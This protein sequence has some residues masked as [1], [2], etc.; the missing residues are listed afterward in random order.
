[1]YKISNLKFSYK[2]EL[3]LKN[4]N[5]EFKDTGLYYIVGESGSGKST[6]LNLISSLLSGYSGNI[7][8]KNKELSSFS[9]EEKLNY[10]TN[11]V[12]ICLQEDIFDYKLS[13]MDNL[14]LS[15][16]IF[17]ISKEE[18]IKK[19]KYYAKLIKVSSLLNKRINDLSGGELKRM[20]LLRCLIREN[21]ILL[22]DEPLGPLDSENS[23]NITMFLQKLAKTCLIIVITHNIDDI[24]DYTSIIHFKDGQISKIENG[25]ILPS[26]SFTKIVSHRKRISF[27]ENL[28][29]AIKCLYAKGKY[30]TFMMFS[31]TIALTSIGLVLLLTS[32]IKLSLNNM[33]ISSFSNNTMLIKQNGKNIDSSYYKGAS[34]SLISNLQY[35][36][37]NY[38][39]EVIS[40]YQINYETLFTNYN[41]TYFVKDNLKLNLNSITCRDFGEFFYY[42]ETPFKQ[43]IDFELNYDELILV[44][45]QSEINSIANFYNLDK[46]DTLTNLNLLASNNKLILNL[47]L[48]IGSFGYDY[49]TSFTIKKVF[50]NDFSYI[51]HTSS[52]FSNIFIEEELQFL[53]YTDFNEKKDVPWS[54][55]K[56]SYLLIEE[57]SIE[58]FIYEVEKIASF[59]KLLLKK[60]SE[61]EFYSLPINNRRLLVYID[62]QEDISI[63]KINKILEKYESEIANIS[64]SDSLYYTSD[65]GNLSGFL[66]P[67]YVSSKLEKINKL[68]D[69]NYQTKFNLD[70]FQ[71]T[72][73]VFDED[74]IMGDLSNTQ[75]NP[76]KFSSL[77]DP[78]ISY[79]ENYS[80]FNEV[81]ISSSLAK[82]LFG[83][84]TNSLNNTLHLCLLKDITFENDI[85]KNN[86]VKGILK[87]KGVVEEESN[88]IYQNE[89]F[90]KI[91]GICQFNLDMESYN[92][93]KVVV[94]FNKDFKLDE[95][96]EILQDKYNEYEFSLPL[97]EINSSLNKIVNYIKMFLYSF[98]V[99]SLLIAV[100]LLIV[101]ILLFFKEDES[102][103]FLLRVLGYKDND[104]LSYYF[105]ICIVLGF[106]SYISSIVTLTLSSFI[107]SFQ[108]K[109]LIPNGL[110]IINYDIYIVNFLTF[111]FISSCAYFILK[112]KI[113]LSTFK[114]KKVKK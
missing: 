64:Y 105:S 97:L 10:L 77:K 57:N 3:V 4:I 68:I 40:Y 87:V 15:L 95:T 44:L 110:N 6:L 8:F 12:S 30:F 99:F 91:L 65:E 18:K 101:I 9:K 20:N 94:N 73:I 7:L 80:S 84:I 113:W 102:K 88:I 69:Y 78:P 16:S 59:D 107:F 104:I 79:G 21:K 55:F 70:G 72:S 13:V 63:Y 90:L 61:E 25:S 24:K 96:I 22:L 1:M 48:G 89:R 36:F 52:D 85:Y 49:S 32:A 46:K 62:Y 28:I 51:I 23:L 17:K 2:E 11:D 83:T 53:A 27:F 103:V 34:N 39:E 100:S 106:L 112:A 31:T 41:S 75:E 5:L 92:V 114:V 98:S 37:P 58:N 56:T 66:K 60:A 109:E 35:Y 26:I 14:L 19:I 54:F 43:D 82:S 93:E 108:L 45:Q 67:L 29:L 71:G 33:M 76:L 50:V 47:R 42:T 81:I 86:F 38:I 111:L 74:V